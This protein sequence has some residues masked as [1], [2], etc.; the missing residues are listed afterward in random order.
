MIN[1]WIFFIGGLIMSLAPNIYFITA[2]R[3]IVGFASGL[4]SVVVPVYLGEIA[5]PTLRGTLGT[6]TQF[7]M[8]IGILMSDIFAFPFATTSLSRWL[9]GVTPLLCLLTI[10]ISPFLL[11]SPRWLL[12]RD[13]KSTE[14]RVVIKQLRGFRTE[15]EVE[16]EVEHFLFASMKHKT[17]N[18]SAHS[19][20]AIWD[21]I[22]AKEVRLLVISSI[23]LQMGQQLCGT[24]ICTYLYV[25]IY[26]YI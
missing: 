7:A 13:E 26:I 25:Y 4:S 11:E 23:V 12:S 3:L 9:F 17:S 16:F 19:S 10:T 18:T 2:A 1:I 14:A 8:V 5:P 21:L 24:Y 6:C 20:S 22:N 15:A